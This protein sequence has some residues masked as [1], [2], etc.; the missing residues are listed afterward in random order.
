MNWSPGASTIS[1]C[2]LDVQVDG[3]AA[4]A[5]RLLLARAA[6][7]G[8]VAMLRARLSWEEHELLRAHTVGVH[9]DDDLQPELLEAPEPEVGDLDRVAFGRRQHDARLSEHRGR[10]L[11]CLRVG[12]SVT[13]SPLVAD[14]WSASSARAW[15]MA[16]SRPSSSG[17]SPRIASLR[18]SSSSR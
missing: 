13:R 8:R 15:P 16:S 12:H 3:A 4:A 5:E 9:V 2:A 11:P 1:S 7:D 17:A 14:A 18:F 10:A 6:G